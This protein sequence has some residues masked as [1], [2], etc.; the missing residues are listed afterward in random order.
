MLGS[1]GRNVDYAA[2]IFGLGAGFLVGLAVSALVRHDDALPRP[3]EWT[4]G[5]SAPLFLL[6]CWGI[7]L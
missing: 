3:L 6:L 7:A 5:L 2:H 1:E 4:L